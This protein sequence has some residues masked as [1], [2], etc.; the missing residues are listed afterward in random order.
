MGKGHN[1]GAKSA[2]IAAELS[3]I[4]IQTP[5][6]EQRLGGEAHFMVWDPGSE[7]LPVLVKG[8]P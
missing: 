2:T 3:E 4:T 5:D 6:G 7:C 1:G 8:N